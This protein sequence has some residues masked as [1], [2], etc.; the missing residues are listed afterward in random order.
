MI[1]QGKYR[2]IKLIDIELDVH[3]S[4][5]SWGPDE[6]DQAENMKS[7]IDPTE[8]ILYNAEFKEGKL[9]NKTFMHKTYNILTRSL[10]ACLL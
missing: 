5:H 3:R 1:L 10:C 8:S 6:T 9:P 4:F 7:P 2:A